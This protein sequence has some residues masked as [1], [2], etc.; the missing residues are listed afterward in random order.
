MPLKLLNLSVFKWPDKRTVDTA[1]RLW[2]QRLGHEHPE[3]LGIA[4]FGSYARGEWGVGSDLDVVIIV[5]NCDQAFEERGGKFDTR[6]L[7]VPVDVLVY[8]LPEW[9][10]RSREEPFFRRLRHEAVW[11]YGDAGS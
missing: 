11:V 3:I 9:H 10:S 5:E 4:Y 7:P 1:A 8:S 2:A 6:E